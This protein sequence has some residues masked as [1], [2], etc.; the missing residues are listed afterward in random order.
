MLLD[1]NIIIYASQPEHDQIRRFISDREIAVWALSYVEVLGYHQLTEE[2][3][4]YFEEFF[5]VVEVLPISQAVLDRAVAL[6]QV[7]RMTLG[8]AIIAGTALV[9]GRT[10]VTRNIEDFRWIA[11]LLFLNPFETEGI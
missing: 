6:R 1:S 3:R 8:D 2:S 9:Y 7:R 5:R 10:L 4:L 11:E